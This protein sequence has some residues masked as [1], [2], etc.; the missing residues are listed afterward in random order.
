MPT[1]VTCL[2]SLLLQIL[3]LLVGV[4]GVTAAAPAKVQFNRDIRP[5]LSEN[6]FYCHGPDS[7]T[8]E[9]GLRLDKREDAIKEG[10]IIPGD[11]SKGTLMERIFTHDVDDAMP[12]PKSNRHL[13]DAD[14]ALLKRWIEE[15]AEYEAHWSFVPIKGEQLSKLGQSGATAIDAVV[16]AGL[17]GKNLQLQPEASRETLI[18]RVS[19]DITGLPPSAADVEAFVKDPSPDAYERLVDRLLQSPHYGER[20]AVDWL[21]VSRYSD[22]YGFQVDREREVWPW[23]DW[24]I[25]SYNDNLPFDQFVTW[26]IAGDLLPK[27]TDEQILA[28]AF[29]RLHQQESEG[30]SVEEE[31]RV[32]YVADRIQT[33]S[34]AFLGLTMECAR[35]HDHKYDPITH[36]DY[37][38]LFAFFQNIDEAGLY[39]YFTPSQPTPTLALVDGATKERLSAARRKVDGLKEDGTYLAL[40]L[41]NGF[42]NWWQFQEGAVTVKGEV[43]RFDLDH[44]EGGKSPNAL[45]EKGGAVVKGANDFTEGRHGKAL[46]FTGDDPMDLA[47]GNYNRHE[48]FSISLWLKTPDRKERAVVLH[49]SQ[50]STDAASR[51]YELLIED[52]R[53]K[54]SLIHF[55]PGNAA[56]VRSKAEVPLN[57]WTHVTVSNDGSSAAAGLELYINGKPAEVEVIRDALTKGITGGGHD[58]ISLGERF[59]DRGF[60]GGAVDEVRIFNHEVTAL[61]ALSIFDPEAPKKELQNEKIWREHFLATADDTWSQHQVALQAAR[62]EFYDLQD[63]TRE[64]MV[65][66]ELPEPKKAYVL[67]RGEYT[68][69][70][71]EVTANTPEALPPIPAGQPKNRLGLAHWLTSRENPLLARVTVNRMWQGLFGRGLVKTSEDFGSQGERPL[72]PE[73]LDWLSWHFMESGWDVKGL[74]KTMVMSRT[75]RQQSMASPEV[76]TDDPDNQWLARGPRFRLPAEMIRDNALFAS[77]LLAPQVGGPPVNPYEMEEAFKPAKPSAGQGVYRRSLYTTWR[78]TSPPPAMI[79][80]DAPRRA[81]CSAKRERTDSPLQAL[82]LLN[83]TQYVEAARMLGA[84]LHRE[85]GGSV[86]GMVEAGF[87]ACLGRKPDARERE[88]CGQLYQEELEAYRK[89]PDLAALLLNAG[90]AEKDTSIPDP[91]AAAATVLAQVLLNHDVCVVKR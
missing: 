37:Y 89:Q 52:G 74:M 46:K 50:A 23:R 62:A 47:L 15:G 73:L 75:Y 44:L 40:S 77:G 51:G 11:A 68:Q 90:A 39:S 91:E 42:K 81:V 53:L 33:F 10:A 4:G 84:K 64:I 71:D 63:G 16:T 1:T 83:G 88:V 79:A 61:E 76:M 24:V 25:K 86:E 27:A 82:I 66:K 5:L 65:M 67:F 22:S 20:M 18:R 19:F 17:A 72:Y 56:S 34:T 78:R 87:L 3:P 85:Q 58:N 49:R 55:W 38:S 45:D 48:P 80:F 69:R 36:K 8:R 32:E 29:N 35:C 14:R 59:R 9:A 6:C 7:A 2:Q 54:W 70:R 60:K 30:G 31:Y 26:Q 21:D 28:T 57:Q 13:S 12:P 43:A 41:E